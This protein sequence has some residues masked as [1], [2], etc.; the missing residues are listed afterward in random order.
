MTDESPSACSLGAGALEQRLA[1][2]AEIGAGSLTSRRF[3]GD[4]HLLRFRAGGETRKR[5]E[6]I[7]AAEAE[8]CSSLDLSLSEEGGELTLSIAAPRDART[9]ADGL[10][11]AFARPR[12]SAARSGPAPRGRPHSAAS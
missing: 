7:V 8:C 12:V 10:A 2:I 3:E 1:A 4:R 9:L 11:E 5:L 6:E